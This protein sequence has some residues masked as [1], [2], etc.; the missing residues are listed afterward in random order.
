MEEKTK[1]EWKHPREKETKEES[2]RRV[3]LKRIKRFDNILHLIAINK[4]IE[5]YGHIRE[6]ARRM[7][8]WTSFSL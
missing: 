4:D 6:T 8:L 5:K 1:E 7:L 2:F 3:M